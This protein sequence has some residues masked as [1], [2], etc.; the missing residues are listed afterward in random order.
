MAK[1]QLSKAA[2]VST[3]ALG[4]LIGK[5]N[6][7]TAASGAFVEENGPSWVEWRGEHQTPGDQGEEFERGVITATF[8]VIH[9]KGAI[10]LKEN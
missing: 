5:L 10:N 8:D 4:N 7:G 3:A 2:K 9:N 1:K 6:T